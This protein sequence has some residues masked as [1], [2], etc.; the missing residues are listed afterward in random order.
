MTQVSCIYVFLCKTHAQTVYNL[1]HH[2]DDFKK[3]VL[4][5][6]FHG[7]PLTSGWN[8]SRVLLAGGRKS[9]IW[10]YQNKPNF[11]LKF[12]SFQKCYTYSSTCY[13]FI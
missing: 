7:S 10:S 11:S 5:I 12:F 13:S 4:L 2:K 1:I 8:G 3:E 6:I 9:M